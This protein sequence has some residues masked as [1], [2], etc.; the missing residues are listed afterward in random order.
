M[1]KAIKNKIRLNMR[2][3]EDV[4]VEELFPDEIYEQEQHIR[5]KGHPEKKGEFNE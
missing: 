2:L 4:Q 3:S 1:K 5:M